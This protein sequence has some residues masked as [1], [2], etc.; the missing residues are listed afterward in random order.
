MP[1][2]PSFYVRRECYEKFGLYA[3]DYRIAADFELLLRFLYLHK[4]ACKYLKRDM[5]TMRT[6]GIST[7]GIGSRLLLNKE[8]VRACRSH[9]LYT[10]Q[11]LVFLKYLYKI[12]E[13]RN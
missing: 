6:G 1:A 7:R 9:G 12:F 2:H 5:V 13:L 3:L 8:I 4:I 11:L 10:H